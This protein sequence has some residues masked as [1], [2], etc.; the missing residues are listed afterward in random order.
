MKRVLA[1]ILAMMVCFTFAACESESESSFSPR[2]K[3]KTEVVEINTLLDAR[4]N[5]AK[6]DEFEGKATTM[7]VRITKITSDYCIVSHL[8]KG[9]TS[10]VYMDK[11]VLAELEKD[12]FAAIYGVVK[13]VVENEEGTSFYY[14]FED[15]RLDDMALFDTYMAEM[16]YVSTQDYD[17]D[18]MYDRRE[19][20]IEYAQVRG[21]ALMLEGD[22]L[23]AFLVGTW[24][25]K[26]SSTFKN[27]SGQT[28]FT[29]IHTPEIKFKEDGTCEEEYFD[30]YTNSHDFQIGDYHISNGEW[31]V[32]GNRLV[33]SGSG[34]SIYKI[35]ENVLIY[36]GESLYIRR[37]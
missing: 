14:V 31:T 24:E 11:K 23:K 6:A 12:Q 9:G 2:K 27:Y 32:E 8:F 7:F 3:K 28:T 29:G 20:L 33:R 34:K 5:Q 18:Y 35:S 21:S 13:D 15:A 4:D 37:Q 22:E 17:L 16:N 10:E 1:F 36:N 25:R 19:L 30:A 26:V